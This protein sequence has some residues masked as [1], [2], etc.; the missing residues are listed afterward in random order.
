[1]KAR[2]HGFSVFNPDALI[3]NEENRRLRSDLR[4][5]QSRAANTRAAREYL[6]Q[7]HLYEME[8]AHYSPSRLTGE[9]KV[10]LGREAKEINRRLHREFTE[11]MNDCLDRDIKRTMPMRHWKLVERNVEP[12][13]P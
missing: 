4:K 7:Y 11:H 6:D 1:M 10:M 9:Q 12:P 2:I 3:A 5:A 13:Q 8:E